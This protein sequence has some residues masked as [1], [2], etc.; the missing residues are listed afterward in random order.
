MVVVVGINMEGVG[1]TVGMPAVLALFYWTQD[2]CMAFGEF[3]QLHH[4]LNEC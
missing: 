4:S 1:G 2:H 3:L